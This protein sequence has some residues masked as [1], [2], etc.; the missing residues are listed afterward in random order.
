MGCSHPF[1]LSHSQLFY[2][3]E[4]DMH[5]WPEDRGTEVH[6]APSISRQELFR[7]PGLDIA[8]QGTE[9]WSTMLMSFRVNA[10]G[11]VLACSEGK[12]GTII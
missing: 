9:T 2:K 1:L 4:L 7:K 10:H 12:S 5:I 6:L 8:A 3:C 11:V